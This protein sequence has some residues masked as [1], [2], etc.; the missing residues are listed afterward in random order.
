[1]SLPKFT[2]EASLGNCGD[3]S[4]VNRRYKIDDN[5]MRIEPAIPPR[6]VYCFQVRCQTR[7]CTWICDPGETCEGTRDICDLDCYYYANGRIEG[8]FPG[9]KYRGPCR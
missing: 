2:A 6:D 4:N 9:G 8:P 1:M 5:S 7:R 3:Y